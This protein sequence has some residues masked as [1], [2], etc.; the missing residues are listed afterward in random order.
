MK[1]VLKGKE[2]ELTLENGTEV[3]GSYYEKEGN[4]FLSSKKAF[5][6]SVMIANK[7]AIINEIIK[8]M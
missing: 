7:Q 4:I 5:D 3:R 8:A 6:L 2:I 1:V